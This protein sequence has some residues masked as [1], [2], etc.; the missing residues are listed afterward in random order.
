MYGLDDLKPTIRVTEDQ[1]ECPKKECKECVK[2]QRNVFRREDQFRCAKHDIYISPSTFE[3]GRL[4]DA[5]LYPEDLAALKRVFPFKR[6]T[7][8]FARDNSEDA[9]TWNVFH[10]LGRL[11]LAAPVLSRLLNVPPVPP[12]MI[13]WSFDG[14][15]NDAWKPLLDARIQFGEAT[16]ENVRRNGTE[17]DLI[18]LT[19]QTLI[20]VEAKLTASNKVPGGKKGIE[21]T[22]A[23]RKRYVT[24]GGEWFNQAFASGVSFEQLVRD[25][26]YELMRNWVLGSWIAKNLGRSFILVNLVREGAEQD[27][28]Q[29]FGRYLNQ[30]PDRGFKRLCWEEI[31]R[32]PLLAGT[33][34]AKTLLNHA[35]KT[36]IGYRNGTL[37]KAF[38]FETA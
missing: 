10:E 12:K 7:K 3:Y 14:D 31:F 17:P 37:V 16:N 26:K 32:D 33:G 9:L 29:S 23:K 1:V 5:L 38:A 6:E 36:T 35:A 2:R 22:L 30:Q 28:E 25:Q 18:L 19:D 11:N 4:E 13:F 27:I 34:E 21:Q 20:F 8:R 24:G 15:A